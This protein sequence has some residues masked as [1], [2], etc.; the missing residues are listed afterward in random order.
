MG[1]QAILKTGK[2]PPNPHPL[3]HSVYFPL[4]SSHVCLCPTVQAYTFTRNGNILKL[5][6]MPTRFGVE[7]FV[8]WFQVHV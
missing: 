8:F 2:S 1:P 6:W 7:V 5:S 4:V 3:L